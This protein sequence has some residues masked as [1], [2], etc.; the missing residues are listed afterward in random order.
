[1]GAESRTC[2]QKQYHKRKSKQDSLGV[3][4]KNA[5]ANAN[6]RCAVALKGANIIIFLSQMQ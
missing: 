2:K 4:R 1:M 5:N 6:A 3:L